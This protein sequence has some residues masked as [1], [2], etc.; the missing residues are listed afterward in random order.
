MTPEG[1]HHPSELGIAL[2]PAAQVVPLMR[3]WPFSQRRKIENE[4]TAASVGC[5]MLL[6]T[7]M[8]ALSLAWTTVRTP[9]LS[10]SL[11]CVLC[12]SNAIH[13]KA[14]YNVKKQNTI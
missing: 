4:T 5:S 12:V 8:V 10:L 9:A 14:R 11:S 6:R 13:I 2:S 3:A 7:G 1:T